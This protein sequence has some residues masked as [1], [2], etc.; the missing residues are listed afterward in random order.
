MLKS[1]KIGRVAQR[2]SERIITARLWVR[3]PPLP[4]MVQEQEP[5][6]YQFRSPEYKVLGDQFF[7]GVCQRNGLQAQDAQVVDN[8]LIAWF[9]SE[10]LGNLKRKLE[11]VKQKTGNHPQK[12]NI[13]T[14]VLE[15]DTTY[16]NLAVW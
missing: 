9:E 7:R 5:A 14:A 6:G 11:I 8:I 13:L 4:L 16:S 15:V 1:D 10:S 12:E 2:W 3:F